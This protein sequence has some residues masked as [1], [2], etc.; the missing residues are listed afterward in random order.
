[1]ADAETIT[2]RGNC[3][4]G[5]FVFETKLPKIKSAFNC[6]CAICT[7]KGYLWI[8]PGKDNVN[9]VKGSLEDLTTYQF[10]PKKL[11]HL[12]CPTCA[13]A[14]AGSSE[15]EEKDFQLALNAH[16]F[17][18][19]NT[20]D[21]E[22][23]PYDGA[24]LGEPF[25]PPAHRG[26]LPEAE[27]E[28]VVYTG[29]CHCGA[30]TVAT[31]SKPLNETF[32]GAIECNCSSCERNAALWVYSLSKSVVLTGDE[33]NMGKYQFN[34]RM[35]DKVFCKICGVILTNEFHDISEEEI[36]ALP[37]KMRRLRDGQHMFTG[38]NARV[39]N[40]VDVTKFK[41]KKVDG[42]NKLPGDYASP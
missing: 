41:T 9:I 1:M 2:Y 33:A 31:T 13:T 23:A 6:N 34:T 26:K 17:Q 3:H 29:S 19:L 25:Q 36:A 8:F 7:K 42:L 18:G 22:K 32:E 39:L 24:S 15:D 28:D 27:G 16:T 38:V 35:M 10:G 5:N 21:L 11:K 14:I 40:G 37:E 20:W 4:C 12:F 30:F